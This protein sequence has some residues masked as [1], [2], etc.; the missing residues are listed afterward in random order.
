MGGYEV[1]PAGLAASGKSVGA[2]GDALIKALDAL[3]S[4]LS[5]S[6]LMCGTDEAGL[7]FF[8]DY[9]KGGQAVISAAESAVN[10]FRNVGYGVEVSAHNY[11]LSDAVSTIGGGRESIPVPTA[12]VKYTA[13]GVPGQSGPE[14]PSPS[15]WS[16]VQQFVK[17]NWPNGNP[18]TM[19]AVAGAWR[20]L[21]TAIS[22]A[23]G[24]VGDCLSSVSGHDIPELTHITDALNTL[25]SGSSD[26]AGKCTSIAEKLDSFAGE[27]QSSQ[28]AIRDLLHRFSASGILSEIGDIFT[29]HNPIDDLKQIGHDISEILHTLSSELDSAASAFQI[30]IDGMD[31]LVRGFEDWD[32]KEF[33]RFFGDQVGNVLADSVNGYADIEEGVAKSVLEVGQSIPTMLAHPVDTVKGVWELDKN[34]AEFLNPLGPMFDAQGQKEA[35]E[36]LLDTAKGIVDYKDWSSDRPLVGLGDNIGNIAQV[37]IPGAGEAKAGLTAGKAGEEA[38]QIARAEGAA[39]RGGLEAFGRASGEEIAGQAGKIGKD[40]D[41]LAK[42]VDVPKAPEPVARP[43]DSGPA[44]S[45]KPGD[46]GA[47]ARDSGA[48]KAPVDAGARPSGEAVPAAPHGAG[49]DPHGSG[50]APHGAGAEPPA[51]AHGNGQPTVV[52]PHGAG[53]GLDTLPPAHASAGEGALGGASTHEASAAGGAAPHNVPVPREMAEAHSG[54]GHGG[55]SD[56]GSGS[57][58]G[59]DDGGG[60][61]NTENADRNDD[62]TID[63]QDHETH[64][65]HLDHNILTEEQQNHIAEMEKGTRPDPS[66]YL[67]Q[68]F[69]DHH[70]DKFEGGATRFMVSDNFDLYGIGQRDGTTFVMPTDEVDGLM[71]STGGDPRAMEKALGLPEGY[72]AEY[73]VIRV[74]VADPQGF[75][76]RMPSGNE[77]GANEQWIPGGFLPQ[78]IS[79]AVIDG[80]NVPRDDIIITDM[81]WLD[82]GE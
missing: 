28:D 15:L 16:M 27:V 8:L 11:A 35:G 23:S 61:E 26:L 79:E 37:L 44:P 71:K 74:D 31:G 48:G 78:G 54:G 19:R 4:A 6:G 64:G 52:A 14:I 17:A 42:P 45:A 29:G 38:A 34:M 67:P 13:S 10:A 18:E 60:H 66:D 55:G 72:F 21:G 53:D 40:L 80:R 75:D 77:A 9:R 59:G 33:T 1:D 20:A 57:R 73:D 65:S 68:E 25:T 76:L 47:A 36:H 50:A 62:H 3:N 32:R 30:L 22:T 2:Q 81:D 63:N 69:I 24:D 51:D 82:G 46:D 39:A 70:L 12:P 5:G 41:G 49:G 43:A 56:Y 58:G 7:A